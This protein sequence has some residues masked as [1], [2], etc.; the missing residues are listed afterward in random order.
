[1]LLLRSLVLTNRWDETFAAI[2]DT[3]AS[4]RR[5][6]WTFKSPDMPAQLKAPLAICPP[7]PQTYEPS[8]PCGAAA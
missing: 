6:E 2:S 8:A 4:D 7:S 3:L 1:M 5:L